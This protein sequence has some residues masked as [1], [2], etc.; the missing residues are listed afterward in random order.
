MM[1]NNHRPK[2][3]RKREQILATATSLFS[4]HGAR[5]VTVEEICRSAG[6]SKA[7]FYKYF[8]NK[9]D[10]I[11]TIRDLWV[12]EAFRELDRISMLG[13]PFPEKL[14]LI[15]D[16]KVKFFS[17]VNAGFIQEM[18]GLD[19]V[20][21]EARARYLENIA[22][23]QRSG[24]IRTDIDPGLVWLVTEK[25]YD[26]VREGTW[27]RVFSDFEEFQRQIRKLLFFGLLTR[28]D[29]DSH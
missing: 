25:L 1:R 14:N 26:L 20:V 7:T 27:R 21:E 4:A 16:W 8:R 24:E 9:R 17:K 28:P 3:S 10:L 22:D 5:R 11:R 23:A 15:T 13:I 2:P 6:A 18:V 19:R 12:E 29:I